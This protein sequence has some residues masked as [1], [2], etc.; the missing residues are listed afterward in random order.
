VRVFVMGATG[1]TGGEIV[2]LALHRG[3]EVTA[4][5]RSPEKIRRRD[6]SLKV[7]A[8]DSHS[9]DQ[10]TAALAGHD[11]VLSALGTR[12]PRAFRPHTL[13]ED[14]ATSTFTAMKRTGVK[15]IILVSAAIL[16][17]GRG[18]AYA[19]FRGLLKYIMLDL[20][21]A[22]DVLR[23]SSLDW[24]IV[25]PPRLTGK[26]SEQYR[27]LQTTFPKGTDSVSFRGVAAFMLD[28]AERRAHVRE[29]VAIVKP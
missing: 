27:V 19:F 24:T 26:K 20:A 21:K 15:R 1:H 8:G 3:H 2:D 9:V 14:C 12:P 4:F 11:V 22:E 18:L 6:S 5:V 28:T 7:V 25:R 13:V 29:I 10:L 17:P 16:F 23:A